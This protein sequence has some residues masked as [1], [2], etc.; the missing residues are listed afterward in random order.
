MSN[1]VALTESQKK[2]IEKFISKTQNK[3][4]IDNIEFLEKFTDI[5]NKND[6]MRYVLVKKSLLQYTTGKSWYF[7]GER[8][9]DFKN[10]FWN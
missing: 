10:A 8:T 2:S 4:S 5:L 1:V 7:F 6:L 3:I 9:V